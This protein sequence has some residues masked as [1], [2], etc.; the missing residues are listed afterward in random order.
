[1]VLNFGSDADI[2]VNIPAHAFEC[3]ETAPERDAHGTDLL[4]G[5]F[6]A[7]PFTDS[8][9]VRLHVDANGAALLKFKLS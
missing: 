1:M 4:T 7:G 6:Y 9:P 3:L 5:A 8:E 2:A